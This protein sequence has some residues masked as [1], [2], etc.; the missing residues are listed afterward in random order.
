MFA[1][2]PPRAQKYRGSLFVQDALNGLLHRMIPTWTMAFWLPLGFVGP[3]ATATQAET[4]S[5]PKALEQVM[6]LGKETAMFAFAPVALL[7]EAGVKCT[8]A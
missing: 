3:G 2:Q 4:P 8:P 7:V 5:E 6:K 1:P